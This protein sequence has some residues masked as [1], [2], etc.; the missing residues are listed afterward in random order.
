M[1]TE[2]V[3]EKI[4]QGNYGKIIMHNKY[5]Y[6]ITAHGTVVFITKQGSVVFYDNDKIESLLKPEHIVAFEK[7]E[8]LPPPVEYKGKTLEWLGGA[9][10][11]IKTGKE[12]NINDR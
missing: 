2:E 8:M 1:T 4:H 6:N 3:K 5:K 9:W 7:Q 10:H 12:V 11:D